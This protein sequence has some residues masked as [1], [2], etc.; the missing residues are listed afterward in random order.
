MNVF[1]DLTLKFYNGIYKLLNLEGAY[2]TTEFWIDTMFRES[3]HTLMQIIIW[4]LMLNG[5]GYVLYKYVNKHS[6]K[7]PI[8]FKRLKLVLLQVLY[9][10]MV[11]NVYL[12]LG[13]I[14]LGFVWLYIFIGKIQRAL[15]PTYDV[16]RY[17]DRHRRY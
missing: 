3:N 8:R 7:K 12:G 16:D 17:H 9:L 2:E 10:N 14:L 1:L 15:E 11:L 5:I 4:V 6:Q 13:F